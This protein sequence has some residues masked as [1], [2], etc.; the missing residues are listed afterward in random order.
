M[1]KIKI[2]LKAFLFMFFVSFSALGFAESCSS[3]GVVQYKPKGSC[4]TSSRT[5]CPNKIWSGWGEDCPKTC[6]PATKPATTGSCGE[7][8]SGTWSRTVTCDTSTL[9]WK[10]GSWGICSY[11]TPGATNLTRCTFPQRGVCNSMGT[12]WVCDCPNDN[13]RKNCMQGGVSGQA[14]MWSSK[15]CRCICCPEGA[16]PR[17]TVDGGIT[18]WKNNRQV[19]LTRCLIGGA[20]IK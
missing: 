7:D 11:C 15:M 1:Q 4:D 12:A 17:P 20:G 16:A 3:V 10:T 18:C 14:R 5:C 19:P 2:C 6:D 9:T 13:E 8:G